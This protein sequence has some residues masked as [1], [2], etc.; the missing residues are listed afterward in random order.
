MPQIPTTPKSP[1]PRT[2]SFTFFFPKSKPKLTKLP[3]QFIWST[4]SAPFSASSIHPSPPPPPIFKDASLCSSRSLTRSRRSNRWAVS[5]RMWWTSAKIWAGKRHC[6]KRTTFFSSFSIFRASI[7]FLY[8]FHRPQVRTF[9]ASSSPWR[10]VS[11][12]RS[13]WT[14]RTWRSSTPVYLISSMMGMS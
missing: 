3:S 6:M 13:S 14:W 2:I 8:T 7:R 1:F 5:T 4:S 9:L 11:E 12:K 10:R